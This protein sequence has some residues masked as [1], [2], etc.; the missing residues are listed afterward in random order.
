MRERAVEVLWELHLEQHAAGAGVLVPR[1]VPVALVLLF[2][3]PAS[4]T[5]TLNKRLQRFNVISA[6]G[7]LPFP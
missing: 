5:H 3:L 7:Q 4:S 1:E 2:D 6:A